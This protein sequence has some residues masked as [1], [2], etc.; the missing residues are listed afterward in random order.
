MVAIPQRPLQNLVQGLII[1]SGIVP[2]V[3]LDPSSKR[4]M[5]HQM[6]F[7]CS[8]TQ[9]LCKP[10]E[11]NPDV[12]HTLV[13][14]IGCGLACGGVFSFN[15]GGLARRG[16]RLGILSGIG[17]VAWAYGGIWV[18]NVR[19]AIW[20]LRLVNLR[21]GVKPL[22]IERFAWPC[23]GPFTLCVFR[24]GPREGNGMRPGQLRCGGV[25]LGGVGVEKK[26]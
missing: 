23:L 14:V 2:R 12:Q 3:A 25:R 8:D 9:V 21:L 24:G 26:R 18:W 13:T 19:S 10:K 17:R 4:N 20:G 22:C 15:G 7:G 16:R 11:T 6:R 5:Q 1:T